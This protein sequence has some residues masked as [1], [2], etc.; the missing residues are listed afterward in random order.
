MQA[1]TDIKLFVKIVISFIKTNYSKGLNC[2]Q[3]T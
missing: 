2:G 1:S 3:I